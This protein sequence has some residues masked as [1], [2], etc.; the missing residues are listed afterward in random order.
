MKSGDHLRRF[1]AVRFVPGCGCQGARIAGFHRGQ[2]RQDVGEVFSNVNFET[3][4]VFNDGVEDGAFASGLAVS[5]EQPVFLAKLG[6]TDG[7][8]YEV[9]VDLNPT[10]GEVAF[11]I[12]PLVESVGDG[13]SQ[14]ASR[15]DAALAESDDQAMQ[16]TVDDP[17]FRC[18][19]C[20]PEGGACFRFSKTL[21]DLIEQRDLMEDPGDELRSLLKCFKKFPAHVGMTTNEF[22]PS[23]LVGARTIHLIAI[24]LDDGG[25]FF[26][27]FIA[28]I[29]EVFR[30][31]GKEG[32]DSLSV[33]SFVPMKE[34]ASAGYVRRPE[35]AGLGFSHAGLKISDRGFVKLAVGTLPM[36]V[37]NLPIDN[38]QP[39]GTEQAPVAESLAVEVHSHGVE[40]FNLP[41]VGKMKNEAVVDDFR[42]ESGTGDATLLQAGWQRGDDGWGDW[43]VDADILAAHHLLAEK[44]GA[45]EVKLLA[46][47]LA[48]STKGVGFEL[49]LRRDDLFSLDGKM[50]G[51]AWRAG[52]F[53]VLAL[54]GRLD[55]RPGCRR[56]FAVGGGETEVE[57]LLPGIELLAGCAKSPM[58]KS[59]DV[60]A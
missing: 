51:D 16:A 32:V 44:L 59:I 45:L 8:F 25:E 27:F 55:R 6:W 46:D 21:F 15:K 30:I 20:L 3:A 26:T 39:I 24:A 37:L 52:L 10:G 17:A 49:D 29:C 28:E 34:D 56:H 33:R 13:F 35:V 58:N 5:Y 54:P 53:D 18:T 60:L 48:H 7:V 2:S 38:I 1:S 57:K 40:H 23:A 4:A 9:V 11:E 22:D 43:I 14:F 41:I 42:D 47:L 31:L 19:N 12:L 36:F 50:L